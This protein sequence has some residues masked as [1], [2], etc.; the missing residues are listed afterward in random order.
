MSIRLRFTLL[1]NAILALTLTIF[2]LSL[3][4][5]Q[6]Q[7]TL[8]ALKQDLERGSQGIGAM[9]L[10]TGS[11]QPSQFP[12]PFNDFSG[13]KA[14]RELPERQIVRILDPAGN[15]VA[16][17]FGLP[18]E[19]LPLS[20]AGLQAAQNQKDWW[21]SGIANGERFLI[22][23]RPI[24]SGGKTIYIL[25]TARP[26]TELRRSLQFLATTLFITSL[27]TLLAAFGIGWALSGIT[28]R[29]IQRLTQNAQTIGQE[30]DFARRV[31]Y[32]GPPDEVGQLAATL[33]TMLE[34]LQNAYQKM[35]HA[36]EM[37]RNFV[38][39]VSHELRTPLTTLR[40]NLELLRRQEALPAEEQSDILADSAEESDRLI[41]LVNDLLLLARAD[42]GRS[43][44][45]TALEI[46]PLLEEVCRQARSLAPQREIRLEAP[47]LTLSGDR[48]ALKQ[49]LLIGLDNA[50]KHS[51]GEIHVRARAVG[52]QVEITIQDKGPGI[53]AETLAHA[54]D[55]FYRGENNPQPGFG[56]G[57]PIAKALTESMNG[58]ISL[59]SE[60]N[61]GSA[62]R[63]IFPAS[64][65]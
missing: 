30:R 38:A 28:L 34:N 43:L 11:P 62:L 60:P 15:L 65:N 10:R 33:N 32:Q 18:Q 20:T 26:L 56:L 12:Q 48:D 9:I 64:Q 42:A 55:R 57:L 45:R 8:N 2:G 13:E 27:V 23:T 22:Y 37:Q 39:D 29:P 17:P 21:E 58:A 5:I 46:S 59:Q 63:L 36:L 31:T 6:A 24:I 47:A 25:Q 19:A 40:G 44:T 16:S 49:I 4:F 61:K 51:S 52:S 54:F 3:Y 35:E 7:T 50:L 14:F 41:R 53:S 1:Y